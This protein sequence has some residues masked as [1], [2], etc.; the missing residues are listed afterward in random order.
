MRIAADSVLYTGLHDLRVFYIGFQA[1]IILDQTM[2]E[3]EDLKVAYIY[4]E[5]E[6]MLKIPTL[7]SKRLKKHTEQ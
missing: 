3:A 2:Q 6:D 1:N 5:E 4:D 7:I